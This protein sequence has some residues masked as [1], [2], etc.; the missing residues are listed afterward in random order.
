MAYYRFHGPISAVV[1]DA[2]LP[3]GEIHRPAAAAAG[4]M[5]SSIEHRQFTSPGC[6]LDWPWLGEITNYVL[7]DSVRRK[8]G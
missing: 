3:L 2:D 4:I 6:E 8:R 1:D 5:A 7:G